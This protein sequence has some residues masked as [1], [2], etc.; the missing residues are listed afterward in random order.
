MEH[1]YYLV[2]DGQKCGPF[3]KDE[4]VDAGMDADTMVWYAGRDGWIRAGKLPLFDELLK[5][6]RKARKEKR[7]VQRQ[8]AQLPSPDTLRKLSRLGIM[9]NIPAGVLYVLG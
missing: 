3:R 6:E 5:Q 7:K 9:L 2:I 4:L 8:V 1:L